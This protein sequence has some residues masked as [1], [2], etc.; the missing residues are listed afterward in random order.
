M[1]SVTDGVRQEPLKIL[2]TGGTSGLGFETAKVLKERGCDVL[3][4][5]KDKEKIQGTCN[6][7]A[8]TGYYADFR[9]L[10]EVKGMCQRILY[11]H[12]HLDGILNN[13][14]VA[15]LPIEDQVTD[16]MDTRFMVNTIAPF[17]LTSYLRP[18]LDGESRVINVADLVL[19]PVDFDMF[20][21]GLFFPPGA[22]QVE[23]YAQSK[24]AML[25]WTQHLADK[26]Y[27]DDQKH[28]TCFAVHPGS[29]LKTNLEL[30]YG[31]RELAKPAK[32]L[33][34]CFCSDYFRDI[35]GGSW[36]FDYEPP[37][38][39]ND[40][41]FTG[42]WRSME[43]MGDVRKD[44]MRC[45]RDILAV[46]SPWIY[47]EKEKHPEPK[48]YYNPN[49]KNPMN[50]EGNAPVPPKPPAPAPVEAPPAPPP[51]PPQQRR[52]RRPQQQQQRGEYEEEKD[53]DEPEEKEPETPKTLTYPTRIPSNSPTAPFTYIYKPREEP[54]AESSPPPP[55]DE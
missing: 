53:E 5:G 3:I 40:T 54:S 21:G 31:S 29:S 41:D 17:L 47:P 26:H 30:S 28:P 51:P 14:A 11:D 20:Q 1:S 49:R 23:P 19:A 6:E 50:P 35:D 38:P 48:I 13:A 16:D 55:D 44:V 2:V 27:A 43:F 18:L 37:D 39:K 25:A 15:R 4:H 22:P 46:R 10:R 7:L 8:V 33:A 32:M 12:K 9:N 45:L 52:R 34:D 42:S 36:M 24:Y